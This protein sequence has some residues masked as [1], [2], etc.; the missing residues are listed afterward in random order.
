MT[1]PLLIHG[2]DNADWDIS[3]EQLFVQ[4]WVHENAFQAFVHELHPPL[5]TSES[6]LLGGVGE[7]TASTIQTA[8]F[9]L[10]ANEYPLVGKFRDG[11]SEVGST[12]WKTVLKSR[13]VLIR[14]INTSSDEHFVFST[15]N[16]NLKVIS[17]DFVPIEPYTTEYLSIAINN[18][19][20]RTVPVKSCSS[21]YTEF[22]NRTGILHYENSP[23]AQ[24][25][26]T[27]AQL[28]INFTCEDEPLES[29]KPVVRWEIGSSPAN[30]ITESTYE[31]GL[32]ESRG[33]LRWV[34]GRSPLL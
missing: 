31:V 12:F 3:W 13:R 27:S 30:N 24:K 18:Y 9:S 20:I 2:P 14:L 17:A 23:E 28:S 26:K 19:W 4:D 25:P 6:I 15:D 33:A 10:Q 32:Q 11:D 21:N 22:D 8:H 5:P 16:H 29:L 1:G 34:I 7:Y